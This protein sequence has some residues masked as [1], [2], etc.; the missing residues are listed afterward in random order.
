VQC[1][2]HSY[3]RYG[4]VWNESA[5][6]SWTAGF[7]NSHCLYLTR[8]AYRTSCYTGCFLLY[9]TQLFY[10]LIMA[11]VP[12]L[13]RIMPTRG[14]TTRQSCLGW[15]VNTKTV[16]TQLCCH[17]PCLTCDKVKFSKTE[18]K[19]VKSGLERRLV[20]CRYGIECLFRFYSYGLERRFRAELYSDFQLETLHDYENGLLCIFCINF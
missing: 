14:G 20:C 4:T 10:F 16:L 3:G 2:P 19:S 1:W 9:R 18:W 13:L 5:A 7:I 17:P 15:L 6:M 11:I 12:L 8:P